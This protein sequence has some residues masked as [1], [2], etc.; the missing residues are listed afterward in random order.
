[1]IDYSK[2][3]AFISTL[4]NEEIHSQLAD[5][6]TFTAEY[7]VLLEEELSGRLNGVR[8][9]S[10]VI[11]QAIL[12]G[13]GAETGYNETPGDSEEGGV[14]EGVQLDFNVMNRIQSIIDSLTTDQL[15]DEMK[16]L[17]D[18]LSSAHPAI[19][20]DY[21]E[22]IYAKEACELKYFDLFGQEPVV[23]PNCLA[24]FSPE[25]RF[26]GKCGTQLTK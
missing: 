14:L 3:S 1:M 9:P 7:K 21:Q 8:K 23:C 22:K 13:S 16:N 15:L 10:S 6:F 12:N 11:P 4:S 5:L 19:A 25:Q 20:S 18:Y 24:Y 26:C 2:W 17:D